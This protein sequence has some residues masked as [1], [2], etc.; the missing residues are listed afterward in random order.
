MADRGTSGAGRSR[1]RVGILAAAMM[2]WCLHA[3]AEGIDSC[4]APSMADAARRACRVQQVG[5]ADAALN[6]Q[7]AR[8][9]ARLRPAEARAILDDQRAWLRGRDRDCGL[10]RAAGDRD[11]WVSDVAENA[12]RA[13]CV[14]RA[15]LERTVQLRHL[16]EAA[17]AAPLLGEATPPVDAASIRR[18]PAPSR[19]TQDVEWSRAVVPARGSR[20]YFEVVLDEMRGA[21]GSTVVSARVVNGAEAWEAN[22]R[23]EQRDLVIRPA[24]GGSIR[25]VGGALGDAR[26]PKVVLGWAVDLETGRA[27]FH[28]DGIW[29]GGGPPSS[30]GAALDRGVETYVE[31]TANETRQPL[32]ASGAVRVNFGAQAFSPFAP[33]GFRGFDGP[34]HLA[35]AAPAASS[36]NGIAAVRAISAA[37]SAQAVQRFTEWSKSFPASQGP[38]EDKTGERCGIGQSGDVWYLAGASSGGQVRRS[39]AVPQGKSIL[40]PVANTTVQAPVDVECL[41]LQVP[42][43]QFSDSAT[44]LQFSLNGTPGAASAI[45]RISSGCFRMRNSSTGQ[46]QVAATTGDWV[47]LPPPAPGRYVLRFG[48]RFALDGFSQDVTYEL[49]VR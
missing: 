35:E 28:R 41:K 9:R 48:S 14:T 29:T 12:A 45:R 33:A 21:H 24:S 15:T 3:G 2:L 1:V 37:L 20:F 42:L 8:M 17:R 18:V 4:E 7:Y 39:C 32:L 16:G 10:P 40:V 19:S 44:D 49:E 13:A 31:V 25:I 36:G 23:L 30:D 38:G 22:H 47:L 26:I 43:R 6:E 11:Q 5:D 34:E 27:Y 46:P